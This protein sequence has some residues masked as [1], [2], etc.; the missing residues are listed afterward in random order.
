MPLK[1]FLT[2][3]ISVCFLKSMAQVEPEE[4]LFTIDGEP[5]NVAEFL[6]VYNKN[7]D[8]VQDESQ[9]DVDEYLNLFT[10][11]KLKIKEAKA[12]GLHKKPSYL[13]ELSNY[14]KQLAKNFM[15][16]SKVTDALVEE[17]YTRIS[18]DVN[19]NHI[20]VKLPEDA[21]PEDTLVAYNKIVK[22]RNR[23]L[24][25]GFDKVMSEVHNGKTIYGEKLGYFSGFKM[26][27]NFENVAFNTEIGAISQPFKTS[28]GYH[29]VNVLDKRKSRGER[30]VAHIMVVN[31]ENDTINEK[32]E[33]RI[34]EIYKKLKQ[35]EDFE[36]LAKQLSDD[37][38]SASK[39]GL[40]SPFS[41][42]QLSVREFEDVAFGL[43]NVGDYSKPF[44][45]N[46]GW[47]IVKLYNKKPVPEFE[48]LKPELIEK[49][50][51]DDR[52]KLIDDALINKLMKRYEID[53]D[54]PALSYF[55]SIINDN[56][57]KKTWK[58]PTDFKAENL[59]AKIGDKNV[60]YGDF[61]NYLLKTQRNN[62][63]N[64]SSKLVI[65]NKY[66]SFLSESLIE[67]HENNLENENEDFA[68][69]VN[70]YRDGL[71]LFELMETTI[72]NASKT[73]SLGIKSFYTNNK[74]NYV[75]PKRIDAVVASSA[76]LK[77]LK[78]V[79]K[80]LNKKMPLEQIKMLVNSNDKID[81]IFTSDVFEE[82][83]PALPSKLEIK[84]GISKIY[85]HNNAYVLVQ[86]KNIL[87]KT[88][89]TFDEAKG[90]VI[91]DY[92]TYKENNWIGAL[93]DKYNV[94]VNKEALKNIKNQIKNN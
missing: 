22:L 32:P 59:L 35:G 34:Q 78:K 91:S 81:V 25:E 38:N 85:Q 74:S 40:L 54:Q 61:A 8:L 68:N 37:K 19:A 7:L 63:K 5:T 93:N 39:G 42:G 56:Y 47:H 16:D 6:R 18:Y 10:N 41:G 70:E 73:D 94:V 21:S 90:A 66:K 80:L 43:A 27:Y 12:L 64:A 62:I 3:L 75:L 31:N 71:L 45:T 72:W 44:K 87:P 92:Q 13:R 9:K 82:K 69:I 2:I 26:V 36:S 1:Y 89:K 30:T 11:Y 20:L 53:Y 17:A 58:L 46:Y 77:T 76:K 88:E 60:T 28:F 83:H 23:A 84:K 29:I 49:V 65:I 4:V 57:F 86:V 33:N 55:E 14:K 15:K 24:K 52:S 79:S 48:V 51:R 50:K 67:Y